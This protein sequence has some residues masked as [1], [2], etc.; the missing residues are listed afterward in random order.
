MNGMIGMASLLHD[1][2]LTPRQREYL[3]TIESSGRSLLT[4]INDILD[5][6]KIEA[7]RIDLEEAV[8]NLRQCIEDVIDLFATTAGQK[9]IELIHAIS[10]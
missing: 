5:Y 4:I 3:D 8:F 10:E 2:E 6:S 9:G 7:G 1:T